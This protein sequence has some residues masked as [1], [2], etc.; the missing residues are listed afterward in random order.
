MQL[1]FKKSGNLIGD[2]SKE[3][4]FI[5][6]RC[7]KIYN[8]LSSCENKRLQFRLRNELIS[9][10]ARK[11]QIFNIASSLKHKANAKSIAME[12]L[13]EISNRSIFEIKQ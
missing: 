13:L 6:E 10:N 4:L 2:L 7:N 12:L 9:L 1:Q 11:N 8:T 5:R 3:A